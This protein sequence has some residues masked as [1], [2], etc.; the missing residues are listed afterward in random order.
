[1]PPRFDAAYLNNPAPAYPRASRLA[2]QQGQV[3]L[4]VLVGTSGSAVNIAVQ[5]SS[6]FERLDDA[7]L[8]SVRQWHF[9]PA[10]RGDQAIEAWVLVPIVFRL[11]A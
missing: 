8:N 4:K 1:V 7:A 6:G 9:A 5:H 2:G 11:D 10:K 3:L